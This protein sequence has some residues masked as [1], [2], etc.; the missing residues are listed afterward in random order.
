MT[1][2]IGCLPKISLTPVVTNTVA[3]DTELDTWQRDMKVCFNPVIMILVD[4]LLYI[5][6]VLVLYL[7]V[8]QSHVSIVWNKVTM[9][10][11]HTGQVT[12]RDG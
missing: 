8:V 10:T 12:S 9:E 5:L 3:I 4:V 7:L 2:N 11:K 6:C 1:E